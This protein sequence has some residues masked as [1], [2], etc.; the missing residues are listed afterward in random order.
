MS[1][2]PPWVVLSLIQG[3]RTLMSQMDSGLCVAFEVSLMPDLPINNDEF[4]A[5]IVP[6]SS[7][8]LVP[9]SVISLVILAGVKTKRWSALC[10]LGIPHT[11]VYQG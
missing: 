5:G 6:P 1:K 10:N 2:N 11:S 4:S 3:P 8:T 9:G 7:A